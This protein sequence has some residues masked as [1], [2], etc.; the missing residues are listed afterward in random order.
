MYIELKEGLKI[1]RTIRENEVGQKVKSE[2]QNF[3]KAGINLLQVLCC[4]SPDCRQI[5]W[6]SCQGTNMDRTPE[7]EGI[8]DMNAIGAQETG[9]DKK[10]SKIKAGLDRWRRLGDPG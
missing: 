6:K 8:I 5:A 2:I 7:P 1:Y 3:K 9:V 10:I 4:N